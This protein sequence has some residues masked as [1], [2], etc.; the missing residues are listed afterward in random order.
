MPSC[1]RWPCVL[2]GLSFTQTLAAQQGRWFSQQPEVAPT[3]A[4]EPAPAA[5]PTANSL[6]Q[7]QAG[8]QPAWIWGPQDK[9]LYYLR[10]TFLAPDGLKSARLRVTCDN[11]FVARLNGQQVASGDDW[12][13]PVEADLSKAV[14]AGENE[15]LI[16]ARDEGSAAALILKVILT[17][18][19]GAREYVVSDDSWQAAEAK[20][21]KTWDKAR[22]IARLGSGPWGDVFTS[23]PGGASTANSL[24]QVPPGFQVERLF[25]VPKNELGSWVAITTDLKGRLIASDQGN[26]GLC[27]I[28]PPPIGSSEPTQVERLDVKI[29]AAQGLLYAF[30]SLYVSVN[31]GPGSGL[32]RCRDTNGDDQFDEVVKLTEL[33]GGGEHGPH[34]LRLAP[35]G[36]SIYVCAGNHTQPPF[37]VQRNN[38]PQTMGG[39]RATI[40]EASLPGSAASQLA[41]N[42]DEDLLLPRQWDSNGHAAGILA[43][44]GWIAKTDPEGKTWEIV[45]SGY[46]NEYDFAFNADGELFAYDADME[47]DVGSPWYRPTRVVHATSGSEFG[48]RSGTGKWPAYYVDSLPQ[49]IDTGPG[50]PVGVEFGYGTKFPAKYQRAL[51]ICDWTFATMYAIHIEPDG[52]SYKATKEEF[53]TRTPLPL[54]DVTVGRDGALYFTIGGRGTQSELFRVTYVG[55]ESTSPAELSDAAGKELREL[56]REIELHHDPRYGSDRP[57][58]ARNFLVKHLAHPDRHIRYAARVALER[59][60]GWLDQALESTDAD[61]LI[62]A[63]VGGARSAKSKDVQPK[64]LAAL[65][66]LDFSKLSAPQQLDWLRAYQ[67][68]FIRLGDVDEATRQ[69]LAAKFLVLFPQPGEAASRELAILLVYLQA[70]GAAAKIVPLLA[71]QHTPPAIATDELLARNPGYGR[72]IAGMQANQPDLQ[73]IDYAFA[74]RNLKAGWTPQLRRDYF[75]WFNKA[76]TWSGGNSFQKFLTNIDNDAFANCSDAERL[77]IEA[78]GARKPYVPPPLPKPAGPGRAWTID[79]VIKLGSEKLSGR[80]YRQGQRAYAAA[81]CIV[82]H[83]FAGDGGATG[84]DLTQL[85]GRFNLKDLTE[86]LLDPSKVISDQ[87]KASVVR[88]LSGEIITGRIITDTPDE[89][90]IVVNPED[91]TKI[92]KIA[93]SE[94]EQQTPSAT[95]LMPKDLLNSLNEEEVLDLLAYLLSR[96]NPRDG[97]FRGR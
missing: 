36:K 1:A 93:K 89:I 94:I 50:S 69:Q 31:G 29:T 52:A 97:M 5:V 12:N 8:P 16:E 74:L 62:A 11:R 54:T 65:A 20:D 10:K 87:Y 68:V 83:R 35:D 75:Q 37:D 13:T 46:R 86:S 85:A 61:A 40:L 56:R 95:S 45:S 15:L 84:P 66:R 18:A 7:W 3:T 79:E 38:P 55:H 39:A 6:A 41:P 44:G 77:A 14:R 4:A 22:Q 2:I 90:T 32:Y 59:R 72:S 19:D 48:W 73:Q 92:V 58:T 70:D 21:A 49:L 33:R 67:L 42:W 53:V 57:T 24:F 80:N 64:L 47:W 27:R 25:T 26:L 34:A 9:D 76:H 23:A 82:C 96:G 88:K 81:R 60:G 63:V 91:A 51:Y 28:T 78:L 43:P 71:K 17:K 30:D